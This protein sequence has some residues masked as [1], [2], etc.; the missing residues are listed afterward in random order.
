MAACL[1][2]CTRAQADPLAP[3]PD[4]APPLLHLVMAACD[5]LAPP[6]PT[7]ANPLAALLASEGRGKGQADKD[8]DAGKHQLSPAAVE[9]LAALRLMAHACVQAVRARGGSCSESVASQQGVQQAQA[10]SPVPSAQSAAVAPTAAAV[11]ASRPTPL[12]L[13]ARQGAEPVLQILLGT[14][15]L[16]KQPAA[17]SPLLS[18]ATGGCAPV[19]EAAAHA[20][21]G[22]GGAAA[23]PVTAADPAPPP[24]AQPGLKACLAAVAGGPNSRDPRGETPLHTAVRCAVG[25]G[26]AALVAARLLLA[27]G[28]DPGQASNAGAT[29]HALAL[30]VLQI[31][32]NKAGGAACGCTGGGDVT[33]AGTGHEALLAVLSEIAE[34]QAR[35]AA[36]RAS[37]AGPK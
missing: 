26:A 8:R 24:A 22:S 20:T 11:P 37:N 10:T 32:R 23:P 33:G 5:L 2:H 14:E 31:A 19:Q 15:S 6:P 16:G 3:D 30:Q 29:P 35:A 25:D 9:A 21:E 13:A 36:G 28:A 18:T 12:H 4:G 34:L 27:A 1:S 17:A 7:P